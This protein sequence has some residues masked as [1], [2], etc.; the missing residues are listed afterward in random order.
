M[1]E[2]EGRAA[3]ALAAIRPDLRCPRCRGELAWR[4]GEAD[5]PT[6]ACG[7]FLDVEGCPVLVDFDQS[8]LDRRGYKAWEAAGKA[9]R[10][11]CAPRR[12]RACRTSVA[13]R[14][15][16][17]L[18]SRLTPGSRLLVIGGGS[19]GV[20]AEPLYDSDAILLVGTDIYAS[21]EVALI[22]DGHNLPFADASFDAVWIQAVLEHVLEPQRV[23]DE[24]H[25]VLRAGGLVYAET[26]FM[27]QVHEGAFDFARFTVS[28]HRWLFRR[29]DCIE[30]GATRGA[31]TALQWSIRYLARA[32]TNSDRLSR[33]AAW[34]FSWLRFFDRSGRL[35]QDAASGVYFLGTRSESEMKPSEIVAFYEARA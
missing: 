26:P 20:G 18:L 31:G 17:A 27:Q 6:C 22:A 29:F 12:T 7:P 30:A 35:H 2:V 23:V 24:I 3:A 11:A 14:M 5:C 21:P 25:R 16:G 8:I 33:L 32:L 34:P 15:A 19:I 9:V 1:D 13:A 4:E 10:S 28:G